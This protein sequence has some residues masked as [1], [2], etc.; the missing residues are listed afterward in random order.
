[1]GM[2]QPPRL[3]PPIPALSRSSFAA[4]AEARSLLARPSQPGKCVEAGVGDWFE[5]EAIVTEA[6]HEACE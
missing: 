5:G 2:A 3:I 6:I 4:T 1:M